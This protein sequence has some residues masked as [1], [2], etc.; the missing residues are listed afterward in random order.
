MYYVERRSLV[1]AKVDGIQG[2]LRGHHEQANR[3]VSMRELRRYPKR[4]PPQSM[5]QKTFGTRPREHWIGVLMLMNQCRH[6]VGQRLKAQA[7]ILP[8]KTIESVSAGMYHHENEYTS[9]SSSSSSSRCYRG[10]LSI[11]KCHV[12]IQPPV[13]YLYWIDTLVV[14]DGAVKIKT[15]LNELLRL[16]VAR[17]QDMAAL[18]TVRFIIIIIMFKGVA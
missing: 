3:R 16:G 12:T 17:A 10:C 2:N 13:S 18:R 6:I 14:T 1:T 5:S 8:G 4:P 9:S 15:M 11:K 7:V